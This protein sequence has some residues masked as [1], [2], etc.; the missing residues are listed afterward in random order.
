MSSNAAT[1]DDHDHHHAPSGGVVGSSVPT[2]KTLV[3]CTYSLLCLCCSLAE[4]W[5]WLS[6]PS[7]SNQV[8]NL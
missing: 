2:I 3:P 7:C 6:V 5:R 4:P 8:Y 1:H